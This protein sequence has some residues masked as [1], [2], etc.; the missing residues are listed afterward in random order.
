MLIDKIPSRETDVERNGHNEVIS[1]EKGKI[2]AAAQSEA[3]AA[4]VGGRGSAGQ[5]RLEE[6]RSRGR[7]RIARALRLSL[8]LKRKAARSN[9]QKTTC[10]VSQACC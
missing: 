3:L 8:M 7:R 10:G 1:Y 5:R 9:Q 4:S 6:R 2:S